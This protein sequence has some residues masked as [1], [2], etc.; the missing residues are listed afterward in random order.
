[1]RKERKQ[2]EKGGCDPLAV[3]SSI[4]E[5]PGFRLAAGLSHDCP[6]VRGKKWKSHDE[7]VFYK[8]SV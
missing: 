6:I 2:R 4:A 7:K 3:R 1:M 5:L 8:G